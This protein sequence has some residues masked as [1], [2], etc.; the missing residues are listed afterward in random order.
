[1]DKDYFCP[2]CDK[3]NVYICGI[4]NLHF[5]GDPKNI[6]IRQC[7][8]CKKYF[9]F[10]YLYAH[11]GYG[12]NLLLYRMELKNDE[13]EYLKNVIESCPDSN[14]EE[15]SCPAHKILDEFEMK[16]SDRRVVIIDDVDSW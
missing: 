8:N 3:E 4:K 1:M 5:T 16:N 11:L 15:C 9:L 6:S 13:A 14:N 10:I 12:E 7:P 2:F